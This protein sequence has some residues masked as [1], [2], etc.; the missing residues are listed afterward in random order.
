MG[1]RRRA[2]RSQC[3]LC[4]LW[5][6]W[7]AFFRLHL[8]GHPHRTQPFCSS[9][10]CCGLITHPT[11][12]APGGRPGS[13]SLQSLQSSPRLPGSTLSAQP[14]LF[15][16]S[17]PLVDRESG[18]CDG[19]SAVAAWLGEE[20]VERIWKA[21]RAKAL[22]AIHLGD[23]APGIELELIS[24][25]DLQTITWNQ[26][27]VK[28]KQQLRLPFRDKG[29]DSLALN[30]SVAVQAK[31]YAGTVPWNRLGTFYTLAKA[32]FSPL[33]P[34]VQQLIVATNHSTVL[35]ED[36][37]RFTGARQR[38]YTAEEI[39]AW[40]RGAAKAAA[41]W[42]GE[43]KRKHRR[44]GSQVSRRLQRWPH[45]KD[46][47]E[48][49]RAFIANR[50]ANAKKDFFVQ[51]ATG[52]G[53]SLVMADLL[54]DLS[55]SGKACVI[56][57]KLDL[58]EQMAKLLENALPSVF[59]SRVGTGWRANL[60]ADVF[61]CVRNSAWQLEN[62]SFDLLLLDEAHHY[63]PSLHSDCTNHSGPYLRQVFSLKADKRV[64]FSA[65]LVRN[66]P[67]FD[68]SLRPAIEAGVIQDYSILVPVVSEGDP[69]PSLVE[70]IQNLPL[71][72]KILAFCN[73]VC[74]AK[75][76][77]KLLIDA[78]IPAGHYNADTKQSRRQ[79]ILSSFALNEA[80]GG[81]RVLVTVDVLSEGVDLPWADTCLFVAPRRGI[82]FRQCVG[83]VLRRETGKLDALVIA[84]P[85]VANPASGNLTEDRELRRL[86]QDLASVDPVFRRSLGEKK[87]GQTLPLAIK[88]GGLPGVTVEDVLE[89][90]AELL[91]LR[92][93]PSVLKLFQTT[94]ESWY[95][96]LRQY[97]EEHG[98]VLV[99]RKYKTADGY[100]ANWHDTWMFGSICVLIVFQVVRAV[101]AMGHH[102]Y[103]VYGRW[104]WLMYLG[105]DISSMGDTVAILLSGW[106]LLC[107]R[108]VRWNWMIFSFIRVIE[109]L[110][111]WGLG[112]NFYG[113]SQE[114]QE[115]RRMIYA[116][117]VF[118]L[119][120]W[121]LIGSLY[122]VVNSTNS[123]SQWEYVGVIK[124]TDGV[125]TQSQW[126][127][128]ESIPS[129][130]FF[131]LLT[132]NKKNPLAHVFVTWYEKLLVIFV[133]ICCVPLFSLVS[134]MIGGSIMKLVLSEA[135]PAEGAREQ[136]SEA[137]GDEVAE[138]E[139]DEDDTA[140]G[141]DD[142][143][144][145]DGGFLLAAIDGPPRMNVSE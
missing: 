26:V 79:Q 93:L 34:Y 107:C 108:A 136:P 94:W 20:E 82:R 122:Y 114:V 7:V 28:L 68:F 71:S 87:L 3:F 23:L 127:R 106:S 12:P 53:K 65:T 13:R 1:G 119:V 78:G 37:L 29:I 30:L 120:I 131:A 117:A 61:V 91:D 85:I 99:S 80:G 102:P 40:R 46:C 63:E 75:R 45:Q 14:P 137:A 111:R 112:V 116:L 129:S 121:V 27:P 101:A 52:T 18:A 36:W 141:A 84:P 16:A 95:D 81:I 88:A 144:D 140:D 89:Q 9:P 50:T 67:D 103:C 97:K 104:A 41:R 70:I 2:W 128:F 126:Q 138:L 15:E 49:C 125:K 76:F 56:V 64:F 43:Q 59:I 90:A 21:F 86:L 66:S 145:P 35:P 5:V 4:W 22:E 47:L 132:L 25:L 39:N 57:P 58:M 54:A 33:K 38:R 60:T 42:M 98:N 113:F 6:A 130:M 8:P 62:V 83:R 19:A 109:S 11:H 44:A 123:A 31:D 139:D 24:A 73:T 17:E 10:S 96:R 55:P 142:V 134:S 32:H 69:R 77:T 92:V 110:G 115:D 143:E 51:M 124:Y 133:N 100:S 72:R 105:T 118:G 48:Q 74:E 135:P